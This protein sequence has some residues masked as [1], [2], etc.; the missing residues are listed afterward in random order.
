VLSIARSG[1]VDAA[2]ESIGEDSNAP[3][4]ASYSSFFSGG[5]SATAEPE[6][7]PV[8]A[9]P[10]TPRSAAA[11]A[12]RES[13][14]ADVDSA[15]IETFESTGFISGPYRTQTP[16]GA[17]LIPPAAPHRLSPSGPRV[18]IPTPSDREKAPI[19][20]ESPS[21]AQPAQGADPA[22]AQQAGWRGPVNPYLASDPNMKARRLARV[23]VSD[24][25]V[26]HPDKREEGLR[27]GTLKQLFREEIKKS[28]EEYVDQ[29]GKDFAESTLHFQEALNEILAGGKRI[30]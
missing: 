27:A 30:F 22:A 1:S 13:P 20:M 4:F 29:V 18:R 16:P 26:Y 5:A 14:G 9:R 3:A 19:E 6:P 24:M 11:H 17:P 2:F 15:P 10:P 12:T 25:V 28:Y 8:A 23:L 21:T 7:E